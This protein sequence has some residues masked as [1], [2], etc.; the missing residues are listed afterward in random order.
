MNRSPLSLVLLSVLAVPAGAQPPPSYSKDIRPFF[1]KYCFQC[2]SGKDPKGGLDLTTYQGLKMGGNT[3]DGFVPG[4]PD[5]SKVVLL[6]EQKSRP[7]MPPKN[8]KLQPAAA[9]IR[10]VRD[11]IKAGAKDDSP[12]K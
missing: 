7:I 1:Q 3:D 10:L 12:K 5:E 6:L 2:H 11:W 9:E 8:A 4:K